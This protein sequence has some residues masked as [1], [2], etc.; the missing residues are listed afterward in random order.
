MLLHLQQI[1]MFH[2]G[3]GEIKENDTNSWMF[4]QFVVEEIGL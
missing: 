2:R 4:A 1:L 3:T